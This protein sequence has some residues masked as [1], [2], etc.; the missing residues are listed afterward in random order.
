[1]KGR[2]IMFSWFLANAI[3]LALIAGI[4]LVVALLLRG[5]LREKKSGGGCSGCGGGCS[6][7]SGCA[8]CRPQSAPKP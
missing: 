1:M 8:A 3:N 7:C 5:M 4:V 2:D 6:S